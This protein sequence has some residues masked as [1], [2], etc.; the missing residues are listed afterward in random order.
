MWIIIVI[1]LV[2]AL[3]GGGGY[4]FRATPWGPY[5]GVGFIIVVFVILWLLGF[6]GNRA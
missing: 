1:L 2:L 4:A 3:G 5:G 6:F